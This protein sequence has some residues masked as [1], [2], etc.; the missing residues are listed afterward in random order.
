M[1][2]SAIGGAKVVFD[3][4]KLWVNRKNGRKL[5]L[6]KGDFQVEIEGDMSTAEI[7]HRFEQFK[8]LRMELEG[9]EQILIME[10]SPKEL[11]L[12][13]KKARRTKQ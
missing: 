1:A 7:E 5:K 11:G 3:S 10:S 13:P 2:L 4:I 8:R 12:D 9:D 6:V